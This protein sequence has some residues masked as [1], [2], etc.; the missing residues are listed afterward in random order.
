[1]IVSLLRECR[2]GELR[3]LLLPQD[4]ARLCEI[5][6]L[7]VENGTGRG[8]GIPDSAYAQ[9]GARITDTHTAW[10]SA[11]FL[12]K[13]KAPTV[14][15]VRRIR[16]G[17]SIAALFHAEGIPDVVAG[18][19]ARDIS[20]Y[21]FEYFQDDRGAFPLMAA[22]G[23]VAGQMAVIYAAYHLQFHLDGSGVSL[24]ACTCA[25]GARVTIIGYGNAG[26]AAAKTALALGAE[27]TVYTLRSTP[28]GDS[29]SWT[30]PKFRLLSDPGTADGL[31]EADV[32]IG[33][34]RI[35]TYDT[36]AIVTADIVRRM[37]PGSVIVDVTAGFGAGYIQTSARLTSLEAPYYLVGGV[38]HI[39][40]RT[41]PLGVHRTAAVQISQT[42]APYIC[43]LIASLEEGSDDPVGQRGRII[44]GGEILNS[45]VRR[46]YESGFRE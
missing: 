34:I 20:A 46:H 10:G 43:C 27:V 45:Q 39:K 2:P 14:G 3:A 25:P 28:D 35:S 7:Q 31:A 15:E 44:A 38:K 36:P 12:L 29:A 37:R 6:D 41:L 13:L 26:R 18:L 32:I 16:R 22:T 11:D 33:A 17:A 30:S 40:I 19:L 5:C 23:E 24:P 42:Y 9:A 4:A 21:S 8:L 1:V